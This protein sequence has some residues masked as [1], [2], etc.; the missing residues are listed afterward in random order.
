[1]IRRFA[2]VGVLAL[3]I[4]ALFPASAIAT[5]PNNES[6][7]YELDLEVPNVGMAP[8]GDTIAVTGSGFFSVHPNSASG[9]GSFTQTF[10][11][12]RT[13]QRTTS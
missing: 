8:N 12:D 3:L 1:M 11:R 10:A 4:V 9:S 2:H 5:A 13:R 7:S 6:A